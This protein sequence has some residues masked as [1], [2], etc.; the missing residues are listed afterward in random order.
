MRKLQQDMD[1]LSKNLLTNA[2][3][4]LLYTD[5]LFSCTWVGFDFAPLGGAKWFFLSVAA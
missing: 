5:M 1:G 4:V 2:A 3:G